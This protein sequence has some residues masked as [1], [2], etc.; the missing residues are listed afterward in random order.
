MLQTFKGSPTTKVS[1]PPVLDP[2]FPTYGKLLR[3]AGY[4]TPYIGKWHVSIPRTEDHMLQAYG[5]EG[6]T[7]PDPS[8]ANLQGS[9][10]DAANGYLNDE[11]IAGQAVNWLNA[12]TA[13]E[14]PWCL[15]VGFVNPHDQQF[16]WGGT[17]FQ[18]YN[19][20]FDAQTAL[21]PFNYY[22]QNNG[23]TYPPVVPWEDDPLREPQSL[24]YEALPP[25]WESEAD[26]AANKPST[27]IFSRLFQAA[28][29]GGI[30]DDPKQAAFSLVRYPGEQT[31]FYGIG[32]APFSYWQ[33][34]LDC[35]T[36]VMGLVDQRIGAVI[37]A[38][39]RDVAENT[40]IVFSSDH[41][42]Y[43][44]A[45][46]FVAGKAGSVYEE[47]FHVPLIIVD[48]TGRFAGDI[49]AERM[50]LTSSVDILPLLV[51]LG[52]GGS[53]DW[54][55]GDLAHIYGN[56]H[57]MLAMLKSA[58][59]PGR[60][61]VLLA[62]DELVL[63]QFNYNH[64]PLHLVGLRTSD[65][66]LG[67]YAHWTSPEAVIDQATLELEFYDYATERGCAE[68]DSRPHDPQ[69]A[70]MLR[71]LLDELIPNELRA[72]LPGRLAEVQRRARERFLGFERLIDGIAPPQQT[73]RALH[74]IFGYGDD[75]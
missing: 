5:F 25:N 67:T 58:S 28:V 39:P 66:K 50:G 72:A 18:T 30:T 53:R 69:V 33:R 46:G 48:P 29:W 32:L 63:G 19:S 65:A 42:E 14:A 74:D 34:S 38:L 43:A 1:I 20:L 9:V 73:T 4:R 31:K 21:V 22:S 57:D 6:F 45:H 60:H 61:S 13:G 11:Y 27:Q 36:Q 59:A 41:G 54:M 75:H 15:T 26:I 23:Q 56:R 40:I 44:G 62:T 68:L 35:Y 24:S 17:E 64:S 2:A 70:P 55:T 51:S 71:S 8:G 52:H 12:R 10:G 47:A 3:E 16:F 37:R 7:E 49:A